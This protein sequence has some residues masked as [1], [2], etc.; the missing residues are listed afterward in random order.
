MKNTKNLL[1]HVIT[2]AISLIILVGC[3][4]C[5][6][7]EAPTITYGSDV[8]SV[9]NQQKY[10]TVDKGITM[11]DLKGILDKFAKT[12]FGPETKTR[13]RPHNFPFTEPSAE[14]DVSCFVCGGKGCRLCKGEGWMEIL[15]Y[16]CLC[17]QQWN[18]TDPLLYC[19][20]CR[21]RRFVD[22]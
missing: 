11:G 20:K 22:G 3:I 7:A 1:I 8:M 16:R 13:F 4:L 2:V 10:G 15:G 5:A 14:V 19:G 17:G 21:C 9:Y 18:D 6:T 12:M